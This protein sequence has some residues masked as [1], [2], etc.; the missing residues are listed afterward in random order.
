[1]DY[2]D[3]LRDSLSFRGNVPGLFISGI[4]ECSAWHMYD[5]VW[6]PYM[7]SLGGSVPLIGLIM[8]LWTA[9]NSLLQLVTGEFSDSRGRKTALNYYY[10]FTII[11]LI[12][13]AVAK[14]WVYF[15]IVNILFG[16]ADALEGPSFSPMFA[17]SVPKEKMAVAMSMITLIWGIPGFYGKALGGYLGDR[18]GIQQVIYIVLGA[19]T[20]SA[21]WFYF[22]VDE[23]LTEKKPFKL[24]AVLKNIRGI[25]RPEGRLVPFY[26]VS[27]LDRFGWMINSGI[28]VT[29]FIQEFGFSLTEIGILLTVEM[30]AL[31]LASIP[32]GRALDRYSNRNGILAALVLSVIVFTGYSV[33]SSYWALMVLQV[34][35]GVTVGLWDTSIMLYQNKIVPEGERGKTF[36]NINSIKGLVA[37]PAPFIGALLFGYI[38]FKGVFATS[39]SVLGLALL[40]STRLVEPEP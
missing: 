32:I 20:M 39:A 30:V 14:N 33:I 16:I 7:I 24:S 4:I 31:T 8:S 6:Q 10:V 13:A 40:A 22:T 2:I 25:A 18:L 26:V 28:L 15:I 17:E 38:G 23:T 35:K 29:M 12:I 36:G 3:K 11:G 19:V 21:L 34:V 27:I 9:F 37:I 5:L 1:M